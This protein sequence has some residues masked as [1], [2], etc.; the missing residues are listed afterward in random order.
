MAVLC[1]ANET[2]YKTGVSTPQFFEPE[3]VDN[4]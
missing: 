2:L 1:K 4:T 3:A